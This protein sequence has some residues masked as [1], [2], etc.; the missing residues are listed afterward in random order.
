MKVVSDH[1]QYLELRHAL[2]N[3]PLGPS[4]T[5]GASGGL[6][7]NSPLRGAMP[8]HSSSSPPPLPRPSAQSISDFSLY[9]S[10]TTEQGLS[11]DQKTIV[12]LQKE[13]AKCHVMITDLR[14]G[15]RAV[16]GLETRLQ[17]AKEERNAA[18]Q[19]CQG[20]KEKMEELRKVGFGVWGGERAE[21]ERA[22][23]ER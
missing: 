6:R 23:G 9:L 21:R 14:E 2:L 20:L 16:V 18:L 11:E 4:A 12:E 19:R 13:V 22:E 8:R 3:A 10:R 5:D 7:Y 1:D 15:K 17:R